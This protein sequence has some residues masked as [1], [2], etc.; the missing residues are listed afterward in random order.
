[1]KNDIKKNVKKFKKAF[2]LEE[3]IN[4]TLAKKKNKPKKPFISTQDELPSNYNPMT[5]KFTEL[6]NPEKADL[7][8]D[9]E[10]SSSSNIASIC[11]IFNSP[12]K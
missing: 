2:D 6:K 12:S 7:N 4:L 5:G 9:G 10:I 8:K 3:I 11:G 1:M